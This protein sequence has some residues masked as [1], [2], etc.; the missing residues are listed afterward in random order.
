M[1]APR[2]PRPPSDGATS[3]FPPGSPS[4]LG[5]SSVLFPQLAD[6][7]FAFLQTLVQ[8]SGL[9]TRVLPR[10]YDLVSLELQLLEVDPAPS[11]LVN[12]GMVLVLQLVLALPE[13]QQIVLRE[14]DPTV[15]VVTIMNALPDLLLLVGELTL[16]NA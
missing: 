5:R 6:V 7:L 15:D 10:L 8:L 4:C 12:Y 2:R 9:S 16:E 1:L 13:H 14:I 11:V 3:P